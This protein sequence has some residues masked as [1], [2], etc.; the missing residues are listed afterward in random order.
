MITLLSP[1]KTLDYS[2]DGKHGYTMPRLV[3]DSLRLVT[4]LKKKNSKKLQKLM[5][6]SQDLADLNVERYDQFTAHFTEANSKPAVLAFKGDVYQGLDA[7]TFTKKD[8]EFAQNHLRILSGLYG[9]LRPLDLMQPYRLEM[10]TSLKTTRGKNLYE[11]W[12]TRITDLLNEDLEKHDNKVILNLASNEYFKSI[13]TKKL[14]GEIM[15]VNFKED[16]DGTLKFISFNAKKA[17]GLMGKYIVKNK[18]DQVEDLKGF[19]LEDYY[20]SEENST[21]KEWL[22]IR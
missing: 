8:M 20:F 14:Q 15:N 16:R 12:K 4:N 22:F 18:I 5:S 21:E 10:G 11:F 7:D 19:D 9:L 17:R 2:E 6:I 13:Q 1:A 3:D